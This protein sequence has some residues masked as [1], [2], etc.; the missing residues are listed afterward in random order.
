VFSSGAV[1]L[2]FMQFTN[3]NSTRNLFVLGVSLYLG[4]SI[5]N[6]FHQFTTSYQREPAHTRAGWVCDHDH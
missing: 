1:G 4:I 3:M 2:S 5:P 6:Y